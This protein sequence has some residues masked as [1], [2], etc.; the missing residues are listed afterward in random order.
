MVRLPRATRPRS[1]FPF[2]SPKGA[3]DELLA[4]PRLFGPPFPEID[5][6]VLEQMVNRDSLELLVL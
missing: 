6:E 3:V 2:W 5:V 1:D 4:M